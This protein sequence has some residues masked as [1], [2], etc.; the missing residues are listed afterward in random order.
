MRFVTVRELR[1]KSS[2]VLRDLPEEGEVVI[3]SNG[4][5]VAVLAPV[6]EAGL[7]ETIRA[8]RR[9]RAVEAV[10]ALQQASAESG[11]ERITMDEIDAEIQEVRRARER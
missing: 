8:F 3:T 7:E 5:P 1:A 6:K 11:R 4:H 2:Q 9:A 10:A